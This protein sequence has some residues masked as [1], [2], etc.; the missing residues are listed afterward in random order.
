ME[1][2]L[3]KGSRA[4]SF[5]NDP[6]IATSLDMKIAEGFSSGNGI[7]CVDLSKLPSN[8]FSTGWSFLNR[9]SKAYHFSI[10]QKEVSVFQ[11]IP[12]SAIQSLH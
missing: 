7:I 12:R 9:S 3:I 6:W 1:D 4:E 5:A 2:H 11:H 8:S 10:W